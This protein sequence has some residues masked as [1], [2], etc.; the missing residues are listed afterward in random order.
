VVDAKGGFA[1]EISRLAGG[2]NKYKVTFDACHLL[3]TSI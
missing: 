3:V 2:A 1:I